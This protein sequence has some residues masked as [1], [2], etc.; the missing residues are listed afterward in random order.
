MQKLFL[1]LVIFC[2]AVSFSQTFG[3]SGR[4]VS[5]ERPE[6]PEVVDGVE[7][8]LKGD[9]K[10]A[11]TK[12]AENMKKHPG[13]R[14]GGIDA[15]MVFTDPSFDGKS[16]GK[17]R[18]WLE[19]TADDVPDD[20]EAFLL[21]A[22]IAL[23]ENR[24]LECSMLTKHALDIN[25]RYAA[26]PER[27]QSLQLYGERIHALA[28]EARGN[29][30]KAAAQ[31]EKLSKLEPDNAEHWYRYGLVQFRLGKKDL[32]VQAL[33]EAQQKDNRLLPPQI[34]LAQ[35]SENEGK[36][37]DAVKLLN[38]AIRKDGKNPAVLIAAAD[39]ELRWNRLDKVKEYAEKARKI[40]PQLSDAAFLF[41]LLGLYEENYAEA[42]KEFM[43][44]L[45]T[46]P[47][48]TRAMTGL[49]LALCVQKEERQQRRALS[50][51][52]MNADRNPQ[53]IDAQVTLARV[54]FL[55]NQLDEAE[56]ILV[57]HFDARELNPAGAYYLAEVF[58][59]QNRRD[60]AVMF[61]KTAL[62]QKSN[63]PK[64]KAAEA[65]LKTLTAE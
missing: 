14:P 17:L 23:S 54:L 59:K 20:P 47:N 30:D 21:L 60:E 46:Q 45:E 1:P 22:D 25:A 32:A 61:L 52:K 10:T 63:F 26:N 2:L 16:F 40:D 65:L 19:K 7:A 31:W 35:L 44:V 34:L 5:G 50:I 39:L 11:E 64:R 18:F 24:V 29:W 57:R 9:N 58:L 36:T 28:A 15:A 62:E 51:A 42:E 13:S 8:A 43:T 27:R 37:E 3:Q 41:G 38:E 12:F 33:T 6:N 4:L 48:G 56:K 55:F 53:D 49:T